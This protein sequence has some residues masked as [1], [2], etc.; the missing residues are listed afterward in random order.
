MKTSMLSQQILTSTQDLMRYS[1]GASSL[2]FIVLMQNW[3]QT[4]PQLSSKISLI[5]PGVKQ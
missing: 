3:S 2:M 5:N 4:H 1:A